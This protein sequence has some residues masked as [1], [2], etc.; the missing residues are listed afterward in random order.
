MS[1]NWRMPWRQ[2][3]G[4]TVPLGESGHVHRDVREGPIAGARDS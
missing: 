2:G 1:Y 3:E 4:V